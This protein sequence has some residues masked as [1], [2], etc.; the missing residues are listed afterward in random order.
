ML[1]LFFSPLHPLPWRENGDLVTGL[2]RGLCC[3]LLSLEKGDHLAW[4]E[5]VR[6]FG[7]RNLEQMMLL[8]LLMRCTGLLR[9]S[10]YPPP[11]FV[12]H[13]EGKQAVRFGMG[14]CL[15][16]RDGV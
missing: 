12:S 9:D 7:R 1:R 16:R 5:G 15:T 13:S 6:K 4:G 2:P 3:L 8:L 14:F 11:F 10:S